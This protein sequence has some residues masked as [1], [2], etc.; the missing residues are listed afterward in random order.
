MRITLKLRPSTSEISLPL[1]YQSAVQGML[2]NSMRSKYLSDFIHNKGY[3][4]EKRTF[5]LFTFSRLLGKHELQID[6]KQIIFYDEVTCHIGTAFTEMGKELIDHFTNQTELVLGNNKCLIQSIEVE[7]KKIEREEVIIE[8]LS[9]I[10]VYSTYSSLD[11][12]RKTHYFQP[13]DP[14]FSQLV[15]RNFENK[16]EAI[17]QQRPLS[18]LILE[19]IEVARKDKVVTKFKDFYVTAWLG[20]YR[21]KSSPEYL[22]FLY[23]TGLGG[24]NSQG[25]GMFHII[26]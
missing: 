12:K 14:M 3:Q 1:H 4:K 25:F 7:N 20:R 17:Y 21:L 11:G 15:E 9:P 6:K 18:R 22:T 19:P 5:K 24:R 23:N 2:Y 26:D 10:T 13:L 16:Y 8:M